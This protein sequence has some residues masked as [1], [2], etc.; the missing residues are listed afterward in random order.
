M[1]VDGALFVA[2]RSEV[3]MKMDYSECEKTDGS[4][5]FRETEKAAEYAAQALRTEEFDSPV[6]VLSVQSK[7]VTSQR[8]SSTRRRRCALRSSTRPSRC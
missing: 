3:H 8:R 5:C 4:Q 1:Y 7:C 6:T 2:D